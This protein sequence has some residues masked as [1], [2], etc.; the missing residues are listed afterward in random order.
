MFVYFIRCKVE[1]FCNPIKIGVS[2]SPEKRLKAL[3]TSNPFKL[4]LLDCIRF[5]NEK[6]A[7]AVEQKLH[8]IFQ[9]RGMNGEWFSGDVYQDALRLCKI[10]A[11]KGAEH[12]DRAYVDSMHVVHFDEF[13]TGANLS[14]QSQKH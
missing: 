13:L 14:G 6:Q 10:C 3:Q 1:M 9:M 4:A 5:P 11:A 12:L 8:E 2:A 7:R